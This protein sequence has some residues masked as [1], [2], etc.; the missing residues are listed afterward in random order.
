[1]V[2]LFGKNKSKGKDKKLEAF[3]KKLGKTIQRGHQRTYIFIPFKGSVLITKFDA[4]VTRLLFDGIDYEFKDLDGVKQ[5]MDLSHQLLGREQDQLERKGIV[6]KKQYQRGARSNLAGV[7]S[8]DKFYLIG[9]CTAG[10]T[11]LASQESGGE[12]IDAEELTSRLIDNGLPRNRPLTIKLYACE[13]GARTHAQS[14]FASQL[15]KAL[16][17]SPGYSMIRVQGYTKTITPKFKPKKGKYRKGDPHKWAK[18][19]SGKILGR[20]TKFRKT[21]K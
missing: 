13:G 3:K 18:N 11:V 12:M 16:R 1:M 7:Q 17:Q 21:F 10:S 6:Q 19:D 15:A 8:Q 20:A 14:S 5:D 2:R 4:A 9:H